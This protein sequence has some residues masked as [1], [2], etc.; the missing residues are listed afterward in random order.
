[1]DLSHI[2]M[3]VTDMDGT[4]LNS[5][6]QVSARFF[7][8]FKALKQKHILFVAASGRQYPSIVDKL[9]PIKD[10]IIVVAKNGA[11]VQQRQ[12]VLHTIPIHK[13]EV[14][15]ILEGV[16]ELHEVHPILCG[17]YHAFVSSDSELFASLLG[18]YYTD[19]TVVPDLKAVEE[20]VLGVSLYH[21]KS[22]EDH[23]YPA[24]T[25]L[26]DSLKIKLSG[27]HW[28][29]VSHQKAHKGYAVQK[30]MQ[31]H[32]IAPHEVLAFGDYHNDVEL[33]QLAG[34]SFAMANAHPSVKKVARYTTTSND[35]FGVERILEQLL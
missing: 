29:D 26:E 30:L 11:L 28:L 22:S 34:Y 35:D 13:A 10:D 27:A 23:I 31:Q 3:V 9:A 6:H 8:L 17:H 19:Y 7:E 4:L 16:Q 32:G 1:M 33:L 24:V 2:K 20:E 5:N 15:R 14:S 18:N 12:A 21:A 25:Y